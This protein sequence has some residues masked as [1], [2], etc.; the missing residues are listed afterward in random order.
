L[1]VHGVVE[2]KEKSIA[3]IFPLATLVTLSIFPFVSPTLTCTAFTIITII[4]IIATVITASETRRTLSTFGI[5][6]QSLSMFLSTFRTERLF[7]VNRF[8]TK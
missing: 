1:Q 6:Y 4:T 8:P 5:E 2:Q 7:S 3:K